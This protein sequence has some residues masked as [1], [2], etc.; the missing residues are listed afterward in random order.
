MM[1]SI[2]QHLFFPLP[3]STILIFV[4][5]I[6]LWL[7]QKQK[8]GKIFTTTGFLILAFSSIQ[9]LSDYLLRS[10]ETAY[11]SLL[12]VEEFSIESNEPSYIVV[13]DGMYVNDPTVPPESRLNASHL[14]RLIEGMRLHL[15]IPGSKLILSGGGTGNIPDAEGM[16]LLL[17]SLGV[18]K[19][20]M[21]L[22]TKSKNTYTE[23][24]Q[25]KKIL[26]EKKFILV[27]SAVHMPRSLALF[28]KMGMN[29]YPAPT[30]HSFTRKTRLSLKK[31]TPNSN[32]LHKFEK[33]F[34][35]YLGFI[36]A[37]WLGRI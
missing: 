26:G 11:P 1:K 23:G 13:L 20:N 35:E 37:K 30:D 2:I 15:E 18:K 5:L 19:E 6:F 32:Y 12:N 29:P 28:R 22:E 8:T 31:M 34:H 16:A 9:G 27:T 21:I 24:L 3:F 7:T 10:L 25:L 17:T 14:F 33:A 36:K 4:G